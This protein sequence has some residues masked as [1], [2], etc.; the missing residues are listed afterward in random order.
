M[1]ATPATHAMADKRRSTWTILFG[2]GLVTIVAFLP[3]LHNAFVSWDDDRNFVENPHFRGLGFDQLRWMWTTFHMGHYVPLSWMTLGLDYDVWGMN[4]AGYHLT[5]LLIHAANAVVV[6]FLAR[7]AL[8]QTTDPNWGQAPFK[9]SLTPIAVFAAVAALLFALHPLRVESVAWATERRDVLSAFFYFSSI[10]AYV[11][12]RQDG[13]GTRR[14]WISVAL[15]ICALLSKATAMSLPAVLLILNVYPLR[16]LG[17][18]IGWT[19]ERAR[20]VY[21]EIAPFALLAAGIA[22]LSI[23]A[24]HPPSQLGIGQKLAVSAYSLVF[25]LW[26]TVVPLG[27]APLYEMPQHVDAGATRFVLSGFVVACLFGVAWV[28][29]RRL[30]GVTAALAV[31]FVVTLPMLGVVQNGPQIAADRYTYFAAPA[32]AILA[33]AGL[34]SLRRWSIALATAGAAAIVFA[35]GALTWRQCEVWHDSKTLWTRVL[36]VDADSPTAHSA[37][38]N[39]LYREN[40]VPEAV[41]HSERAVAIA[42]NL[43]E[44]LNGLGVGFAR[45]GR[46]ADAIELFRRAV[47]LRPDYTDAEANWGVTLAQ[48]ND[49]AGAIEHYRR[50]LEINPD[51]SNAHVNWGNALVRLHQFDEAIGHY[52]AALRIRPDNAEA[53]HNWGVALAQQ[54]KFAEAIEHFRAALAIDPNHAEAR[55]Y[56]DKASQLLREQS[57]TR[58]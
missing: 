29:R 22:A 15:F 7:W 5:S 48:Q 17:G 47:A 19:S 42:P 2:I 3:V 16:R 26:K 36:D 49:V 39:V 34:L 55:E 11:R 32:I 33:G 52:E 38:S 53:Q 30:P 4:P 35:L 58:R 6:Y 25:Y 21:A 57:G 51:N 1:A 20:G 13:V 18:A 8:G 43:P 54:R 12:S 31:F 56:L 50:A 37:L 10:L 9:W 27:L 45:E 41:E 44:A 14:Y 24:L 46:V 40:R 28:L 23:V